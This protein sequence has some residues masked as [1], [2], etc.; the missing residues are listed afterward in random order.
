MDN[1]CNWTGEKF[2]PCCV[3]I[4]LD[5]NYSKQGKFRL[6]IGD[7]DFYLG[8]ASYCPFCGS[9]IIKSMAKNTNQESVNKELI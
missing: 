9:Y 4:G 2:N 8:Y 5:R 3:K 7:V 6:N 1:K